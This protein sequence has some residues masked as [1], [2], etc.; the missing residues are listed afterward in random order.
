[1]KIHLEASGKEYESN[2]ALNEILKFR[3]KKVHTKH[4]QHDNMLKVGRKFS[5]TAC[6][7]EWKRKLPGDVT[8]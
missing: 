8:R 6:G 3:T 1:M 7:R 4:V 2:K 5:T